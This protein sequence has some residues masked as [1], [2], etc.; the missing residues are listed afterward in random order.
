MDVVTAFLNGTL[1]EEIYMLQPE[2]FVTKGKE[3]LV[4]HLRKSLYCL[5]QSPRC[6]YEELSEYLTGLDF[7]HCTSEPCV[8][9]RWRGS[10]LTIITVYVDDLI[11]LVDVIADL[12]DLKKSLTDRFRMK[13]L[14]PLNHCLGI[15]I[16]QSDSEIQIHQELYIT[17]MLQ[18][19]GLNDG[20]PVHTPADPSVKLVKDDGISGKADKTLFRQI[21]GS[22]QYVVSGTRPDIAYAVNAVVRFSS[23]PSEAHL[24]AAKRILKYLKGTIDLALTYVKTPD[25]E[26]IGYSDADWAGDHNSRK[27]TSGNVFVLG[28][29]TITWSSWKQTSVALSTVEAEYIALCLATQEVAWIRQLLDELDQKPLKPTIMNEDNQGAISVAHNPVNHKRTKHIDII[30][31]YVREAVLNNVIELVYCP[32]KEMLADVFTKAIPRDQFEYL[33]EMMGLKLIK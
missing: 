5:K 23:D 24:A 11:R 22:L 6:W 19:F 7:E 1:K 17:N 8:F 13:D 3:T 26:V 27:S 10:D 28:S 12:I 33:R 9:F 21:I 16:K 18:K 29:S 30:F 32:T 15:S 20:Y 25:D 2:G 14:G 31:H 4:C